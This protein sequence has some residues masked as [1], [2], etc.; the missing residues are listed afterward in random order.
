MRGKL[1]IVDDDNSTCELLQ[2]S[3]SR[4]QF[5][6][7]WRTSAAEALA[8]IAEREF[9]TIITDLFMQGI[10]GIEFCER[11]T[12]NRDNLPVIVITAFGN[13]NTAI[14]AIRAGAYDF[15]AKPFEI[16]EL[17]LALDRAIKHKNLKEEVKRLR[18]SAGIDSPEMALLGESDAIKNLR[19]MIRKMAATDT[20]VLISGGTGTGK[21][22]VAQE[23]H[24][25]SHRNAGPFI[26]I[27][28][29]A[30]PENLLESEL[31][32]HSRGAFTDAKAER[33]GLFVQAQ[34]GTFFLDEIGSMPLG[35]QPKVL[36]ALQDRRVRPIGSNTE[37][38]FDVRI[39]SATN[40]DLESAVEE[41]RFRQDLFF[42]LNVIYIEVPPLRA[43]G[44]DILLLAQKF[45]SDFSRRLN[46]DVA[47]LSPNAA[48]KLQSYD[49][50]GNVRELQN[51]IERAVALATHELLMVEDFPEKIRNYRPSHLFLAGDDPHDLITLEELERRYIQKVLEAVRGNKTDASR[52]LGLDRKTLYRKLGR[53]TKK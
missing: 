39:I 50:P 38:P 16:E 48:E 32:G 13:L 2:S 44:S 47:G 46:K 4:R 23:L 28:C 11:I 35:L 45:I 37:I 8:L 10:D 51:C 18:E 41:G 53:Y 3:L 42:R 29:A 52:I 30:V 21:E 40:A 5:E 20:S 14:A 43:R 49:W 34:G 31:F 12:A 1:L 25:L 27:N 9:D 17:V 15:I 6:V 19:A 7:I 33:T 24:G 36:R 22:L 26:A